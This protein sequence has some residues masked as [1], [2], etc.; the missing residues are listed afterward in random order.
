LKLSGSGPLNHT[1]PL[2]E[3]DQSP[4]LGTIVVPIFNEAEALRSFFDVL[5]PV[6]QE[7]GLEVVAVNDGSRDCSAE[8]LAQIPGIIFVNNRENRG[9]GAALKEGTKHSTGRVIIIIDADGTYSPHDIPHLLSVF[10]EREID[11]V[12]GA[13][14][15]ENVQVPVV[16][17]PAKWILNKLANY[18]TNSRIPDLNSG[19]RV[20]R[21]TLVERFLNLLPN[22]FSFTTTITLAALSNDFKVEFIPINY[23]KRTGSSKIRPIADTLNFLQLIVRTVMYFNPLRI[24]LPLG[25]SMLV[26]SLAGYTYRVFMGGVGL[27]ATTVILFVGALQVCA[28]GMLADLIVNLIVKRER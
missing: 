15:G 27:Q 12:V 7:L 22:G 17:R 19:L 23:G 20:M 24:F 25:L 13:R 11:M 2:P 14:V 16:R 1:A 28:I 21:R 4:P 26:L 5:L 8:L 18:L 3:E 10:L 6:A 9:Y